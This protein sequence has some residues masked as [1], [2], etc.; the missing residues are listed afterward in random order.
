MKSA[1]PEENKPSERSG[2][3]SLKLQSSDVQSSPKERTSEGEVMQKVRPTQSKE[4]QCQR[5]LPSN[6]LS[7]IN[8][9]T[10]RDEE[11]SALFLHTQPP[12]KQSIQRKGELNITGKSKATNLIEHKISCDTLSPN[13]DGKIFN[14]A[15]VPKEK[16]EILF[17]GA[18]SIL[19]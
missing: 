2:G 19:I 9:Q 6:N 8:Y 14:Q 11:G 4:E 16:S 3:Y 12:M 17:Q 1:N 15:C 13:C 10:I 7:K 5:F 18:V